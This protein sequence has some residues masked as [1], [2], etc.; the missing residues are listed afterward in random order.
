MGFEL[1]DGWTP[2]NCASREGHLEIV[3]RLIEAEANVN[4]TSKV[5]ENTTRFFNV[6]NFDTWV[7]V[8]FNK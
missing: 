8:L 4:H 3:K 2:L 7:S 6:V 1:Q 5:V